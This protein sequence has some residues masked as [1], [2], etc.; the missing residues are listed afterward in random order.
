MMRCPQPNLKL[1]EWR[2]FLF[3][4]RFTKQPVE[5]NKIKTNKT[6]RKPKR[7]DKKFMQKENQNVMTR[8]LCR[9]KDKP[10]ELIN[11]L[12]SSSNFFSSD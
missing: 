9:N 3:F 8:N 7:N 10:N 1:S 6:E 4:R 5:K 2:G 11:N 12:I